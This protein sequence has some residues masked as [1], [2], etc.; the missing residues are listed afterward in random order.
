MS[1]LYHTLFALAALSFALAWLSHPI[2]AQENFELRWRVPKR[3]YLLYNSVKA[4][5]AQAKAQRKVVD[6]VDQLVAAP[7]RFFHMY[8]YEIMWP[9]KKEQ[10]TGVLNDPNFP[11]SIEDLLMQLA[12]HVPG[13]T[14]KQGD[15]Y[16]R[17]WEFKR[18]EGLPALNIQS[19]YEVG[20]AADY[21]K[22]ACVIVT[23]KH[24]LA[25]AAPA[26]DEA[27]PFHVW[28]QFDVECIAYFNLQEGRLEGAR[29]NVRAVSYELSAVAESVKRFN[30]YDWDVEWSLAR[31]FDSTIELDLKRYVDS[32]IVRGRERL[33]NMVNKENMWPS[34]AHKRGGTALAILALLICDIA[35]EHA[36]IVAGFDAMKP[37]P[38]DNTYEVAISL[39]AFEAKYIS[40]D[41]KRSF[42]D[43]R[44]VDQK[45]PVSDADKK[46]MQRLLEWLVQ[47]QNKKNPFWN[48]KYEAG[49]TTDRFD[50]SNTQYALLALGSC[51]RCGI[52]IPP[53]IIKSHVDELR[54]LQEKD[55][56]EFKRVVGGKPPK[57]SKGRQTSSPE[58]REPKFTR[59][60]K[61][62]KARGW[63]YASVAVYNAQTAISSS[64]GS[65][66]SSALTCL[67]IGMDIAAQ[68]TPEQR[69]TE[70]G[71]DL[72]YNQ[73][74][75]NAA[76]SFEGGITWM[77]LH[78]SVTRNAN[79]GRSWYYYYMY[80]LERVGVLCDQRYLGEHDWYAEG[81]SI[82]VCLQ[83]PANDWA[84]NAVDTSFALLFLKRG[85]IPLKTPP[86]THDKS[87]GPNRIEPFNR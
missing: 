83:T 80:G 11:I 20:Q 87:V 85:T 39:M 31:S 68:M 12:M 1:R 63:A 62:V 4:E 46:E 73:W 18:V 79:L 37:L 41:E 10:G 24:V 35:P 33:L 58:E 76:Q 70:F 25:D 21:N 9:E 54:K 51:L 55:G 64:Y 13:K 69:R 15:T 75:Q 66:T 60:G 17:K 26:A 19:M 2:V 34:G 65:M 78:F 53:G 50:L 7:S 22:A 6:K 44:K 28:R 3:T 49:G 59:A 82:L 48:Y 29:F 56:P 43:G 72:S 71:S 61:T 74:R 81:A 45:R 40:D 47:N 84:A 8:G 5:Q 57:P 86:P 16:E 77:D 30:Y 32:A 36:A 52:A 67:M 42:L 38:I 23:G 14:E 27:K